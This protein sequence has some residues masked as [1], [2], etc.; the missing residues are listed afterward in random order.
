MEIFGAPYPIEQ[1]PLGFFHV[2]TGLDQTKSDLLALLLTNPNERIM[3][4]DFGVPLR[5]LMFEQSSD[6]LIEE[7]KRLITIAIRTWE[8][9]VEIENIDV[10]FG[11]EEDDQV[12]YI[13]IKFFDPNN[14]T[15]LQELVLELPLSS[16]GA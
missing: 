3:L 6:I 8:P 2:Q 15:E 1:H 11:E 10:S 13:K 4:N 9:R 7:A 16:S 5:R 14:I 12:L